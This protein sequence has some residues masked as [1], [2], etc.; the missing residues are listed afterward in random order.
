M[1]A[2]TADDI[3]E[4]LRA[5]Y[6][7]WEALDDDMAWSQVEGEPLEWCGVFMAFAFQVNH[8]ISSSDSES[9]R[10]ALAIIDDLL[11]YSP[12][13]PAGSPRSEAA[14]SAKH[15][16]YAA[17]WTCFV[18]TVANGPDQVRSAILPNVTG[19]RVRAIFERELT[20]WEVGGVDP[21]GYW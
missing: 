17:I 8:W 16:L 20:T 5:A 15:N 2:P 13:V 10:S 1:D 7:N 4:I 9:I 18:D 6:P 21:L 11:A 12:P 14:T 3:V 19:E